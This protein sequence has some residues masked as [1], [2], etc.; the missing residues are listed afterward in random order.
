MPRPPLTNRMLDRAEAAMR[1]DPADVAAE[2]TALI[3]EDG[4]NPDAFF[5]P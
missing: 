3:Q 4:S 5:R 1:D 2:A